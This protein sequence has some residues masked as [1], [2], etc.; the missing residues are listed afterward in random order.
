MKREKAKKS[1]GLSRVFCIMEEQ[2]LIREREEVLSSKHPRYRGF[3]L[4]W[5]VIVIFALFLLVGLSIDTGKICLVNHQLHNAAD[6][7][8]LASAPWVK[9]DKPYTRFLAEK[10]AELNYAD[11]NPCLVDQNP[12]NEFDGDVILGKYGFFPD[13]DKYLFVPY[14]PEDPISVNAVAV[15][16]SR[17]DNVHAGHELAAVTVRPHRHQV[18]CEH[19][20]D[21]PERGGRSREGEFPQQ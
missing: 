17:D 1:G 3:G 19:E 8:A 15:I 2:N 20:G 7:G 18:R 13:L 12:D 11:K 16:T 4:T 10:F 9:K 14:D 6:A 5:T 21:G